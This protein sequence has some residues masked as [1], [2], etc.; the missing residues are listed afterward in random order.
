MNHNMVLSYD[1]AREKRRQQWTK[2]LL[3]QAFLIAMAVWQCNTACVSRW[4]RSRA[5]IK[6]TKCHHQAT[7]CSVLPRRPPGRQQLKQRCKMCPLCCPF[8]WPS[9]R[10][11]TIPCASPNGGSLAFLKA[12]KRC[13]RVSTRS[14]SINRT[15]LHLILGV[16]FIVKSLK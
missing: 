12:T 1:Y 14:D 9:R 8:Q 13:H 5:F 3:L 15:R 2:A 6:S 10:G 4:K 11:G 7:T 16:Y